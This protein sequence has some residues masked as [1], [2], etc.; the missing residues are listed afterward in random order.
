M[1]M[2]EWVRDQQPLWWAHVQLGLADSL[3]MLAIRQGKAE[4]MEEALA[5]VRG[6]IDVYQDLKESYWHQAANKYLANI[7]AGRDKLRA[8]GSIPVR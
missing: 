5:R 8:R 6:A 3:A 4:T 1:A 2:D 7:Q